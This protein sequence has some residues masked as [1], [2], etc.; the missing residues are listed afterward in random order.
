VSEFLFEECVLKHIE[1]VRVLEELGV[2]ENFYLLN[3]LHVIIHP[4]S[5]LLLSL[6]SL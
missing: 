5:H 1:F 4:G 2:E 3:F 6:K